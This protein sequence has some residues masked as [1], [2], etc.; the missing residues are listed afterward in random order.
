[1]ILRTELVY[2]NVPLNKQSKINE[3]IVLPEKQISQKHRGIM[4][5]FKSL[6]G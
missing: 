2:G 3:I 5:L 1:M 6:N 4:I